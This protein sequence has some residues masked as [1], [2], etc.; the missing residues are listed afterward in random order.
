MAD[1]VSVDTLTKV[2]VGL[3]LDNPFIGTLATSLGLK[4]DND[5]PTAYTNGYEIG[6]NE[7]FYESLTRKEQTGVM[8][9]EIFH[10]MLMHHIRMF[11]PWMDP[12][13]AQIAADIIVNAMCLE[14]K[15]ELPSDGILP[16]T[17]EGGVQEY[18]KISR[19]SL[20]EAVRYLGGNYNP[21]DLPEPGEISTGLCEM[22]P[23]QGDNPS[24]G[25]GDGEQNGKGGLG[26]SEEQIRQEETRVKTAIAKAFQVAKQQGDMSG[27]MER[28]IQDILNPKVPWTEI[29][30]AK[31][32]SHSKRDAKWF[33]PNRRYVWQGIYLPSLQGESLGHI[34]WGT[35]TSGS[36]DQPTI[37]EFNAELNGLG[38]TYDMTVTCISCDSEVRHV[39]K[40]SQHDFPV[41]PQWRGGGG[42]NYRPVFRYIAEEGLDIRALVYITDGHCDR[43]PD[44]K[45]PY[46]VYWIVWDDVPFNPP[47]GE[48][49][50][51]Q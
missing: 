31:L 25:D 26:L 19:M 45:P 29:I 7:K 44:E 30:R 18:F 38:T 21:E 46:D 17:W 34:G 13:T 42:T 16:E 15:F 27:D 36:V 11:A 10:V 4:I 32:A 35:D 22:P 51:V 28:F 50:Y 5:K 40:F 1:K 12:K 49:I 23:M 47:F 14:H 6:V 39:E 9:H 48:T 43:F 2:R 8:A 24:D 37:D 20:E 3:L 41:T 33:P